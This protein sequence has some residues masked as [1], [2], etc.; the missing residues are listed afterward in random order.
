MT[1][2]TG[3]LVT[4]CALVAVPAALATLPGKN[5]RIA[6]MVKDPTGHW[7]VWVAG[8]RLAGASRTSARESG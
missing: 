3:A 6:Y 7:Q 2:F 8:G 5:G 1:R 4:L